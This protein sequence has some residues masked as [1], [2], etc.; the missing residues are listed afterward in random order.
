MG[1]GGN[2]YVLQGIRAG[3][4]AFNG[5]GTAAAEQQP[6]V[7][8]LVVGRIP[9][10]PRS[11]VVRPQTARLAAESSGSWRVALVTG[12]RGAGKTHVAAAYA[13]NRLARGVGLA[14]WVNAGSDDTLYAGL[15]EVALRL[16][17]ADPGDD[18]VKAAYRLRDH[19]ATQ[20]EAGLLV[21]DNA[22]DVDL[23]RE[24]LPASGNTQIVIT[25]TVRSFTSLAD[26]L[27]DA[28][29]GYS[30]N[31]SVAYLNSVTDLNDPPGAAAVAAELGDLPLALA[32]AAAAIAASGATYTRFLQRVRSQPLPRALRH[33]VGQ[34][35]RLRVDQA[36][37]LSLDDARIPTGDPGLDTTIRWLLDLFAVFDPAGIGRELLTHPDPE[38]DE[39]IDD[40]I[41]HCVQR[42]LLTWSTGRDSLLA[43]RL[44]ARALREQIL[45]AD[46]AE[47][48][49]TAALDL[50]EPHL[51]DEDE[52]WA[53]RLEGTRLVDHIDAITSS[54][55]P[56][57]VTPAS[58]SRI[59]KTQRWATRQLTTTAVLTRAIELAHATLIEHEQILGSKHPDTLNTRHNLADAYQEAGQVTSAIDLYEQVLTDRRRILGDDHP[60]TLNTRNNLALAHQ[61]AGQLTSAIDLYEQVLTDRRRILGD[62]HPHTLNTRN[63]LADAYQEAGQVSSA[64]DLYEQVLTDRRRILGEDHPDTLNTRHN[65]A[66]AYQ[67]AGQVGKAIELFEQ[68]LTDYLR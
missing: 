12:M 49:L 50:L 27:V 31:Q 41:D 37:T 7:S 42:S 65:L 18:P 62:S 56:R 30:R 60:H 58:R 6:I 66:H 17:T 16:G 25:S 67:E 19:L 11:F 23:V 47:T 14:G 44:T 59:L 63:N 54:G 34:E 33:R 9:N 64:I 15:A 29:T 46:H 40:A 24:L 45:D 26:L 55:L 48:V 51:F 36:I 1:F 3:R 2:T 52:A 8:P 43:H 39:W 10:E 4:I 28:G 53:R 22:T 38:L 57:R 61:E 35:H 68:V 32:T 20:A 13:R 5:T 21:L